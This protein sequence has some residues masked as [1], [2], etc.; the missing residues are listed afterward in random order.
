MYI[1]RNSTANSQKRDGVA[2]P[3]LI[4]IIK[5]IKNSDTQS[6]DNDS[7]EHMANIS[8][9]LPQIWHEKSNAHKAKTYYKNNKQS[10]S[11]RCVPILKVSWC[12]YP[13]NTELKKAM[14]NVP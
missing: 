7:L 4:I 13:H 10:N 11:I 12:S 2:S 1:N 6:E 14:W 5:E 8:A 9:V 3:I